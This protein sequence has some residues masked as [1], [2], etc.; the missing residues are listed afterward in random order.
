MAAGHFIN[1][2]IGTAKDSSENLNKL[3]SEAT[4]DV[5]KRTPFSSCY[6]TNNGTVIYQYSTQMLNYYNT[7]QKLVP[8]KIELKNC[9]KGWVCD[10]QPY[11]CY[12]HL[13]RSTGITTDDGSEIVF[14]ADNKI[15]GIQYQQ[16]IKSVGDNKVNID[17]A[18]S[19]HKNIAFLI[20]GIKTDYVFDQPIS[21]NLEVSESVTVPNGAVLKADKKRGKMVDGMWQGDYVL[22][23]SD[24]SQLARFSTP[25]CYDAHKKG[26][27]GYYYDTYESGKHILHTVVP[28]KWLNQATYP[29]TIDPTVIGPI[30]H[31]PNTRNIPSGDFPTFVTDSLLVTIPGG[32]TITRL[33]ASFCFVTNNNIYYTYG[34]IFFKT[35][36]STTPYLA[37]DSTALPGTCY[38]DTLNNNNDFGPSSSLPLTCCFNPSCSPQTFYFTVGLA[39]DC[40]P[41]APCNPPGPDSTRW[42]WS[43]TP[44]N[45][46]PFYAYIVGK[47]DEASWSISPGTLCSNQCTLNLTATAQYGVPPYKFTH[48]WLA[49]GPVTFGSSASCNSSTGN[50][51]A[52]LIIPGCPAFCGQTQNL[53]VPPPVI[54]DAC[55]DTVKGLTAQSITINPVPRITVAPDSEI[56]C[57]GVPLNFDISSCVNGTTITWKGTDNKTGSDS[58]VNY[59]PVDTVNSQLLIKY[60]GFSSYNGCNGDTVQFYAKISQ[61]PT[62]TLTKDTVIAGGSITLNAASNGISYAWSP[63][64]GLSCI[65][66][67]NPVASPTI[68]TKYYVTVTNPNG[69]TRQDSVT[70]EI[71]PQ[72]I[73]IP[74]VFTPNGD[75]KNDV[76]Y[77]KNLQYYPNSQLTIFDRWG[78][79][80][81]S[82]SNYLNNWDGSGQ[83]DGVY[84][85][86]L[87]LSNDK[88]YDGYIELLR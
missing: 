22:L 74:N 54:Y 37:C 8:I 40:P 51:N 45:P 58:M 50:L 46:Y 19:I 15:N 68:T 44:P 80:V 82:T 41:S 79:K 57:S 69:C 42:L 65:N 27:L 38:L 32:I 13:D 30:T 60:K 63:P 31:W 16:Q 70:I 25:Q 26:C 43:P 2:P 67:P 6:K 86:E 66:C 53:S 17:M 4:E 88:K 29:V 77:I 9:A 61:S 62:L 81:L 71:I 28:N 76:F 55:N 47:T 23:A 14:N 75:G 12:F 87:V 49:G 73:S 21:N 39:R 64:T 33:Y 1:Q 52:H 83:S 85:Y 56:I 11:P 20:N 5:S 24:G 34:R 36:C 3:L 7:E 35:P 72:S 59:I 10:Q 48:P 18:I 78:V 84:Y